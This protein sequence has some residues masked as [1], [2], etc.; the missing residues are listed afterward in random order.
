MKNR[1]FS[2]IAFIFVLSIFASCGDGNDYLSS[3]D[4]YEMDF[5]SIVNGEVMVRSA[6]AG[7]GTFCFFKIR[8]SENPNPDLTLTT[9]LYNSAG[10]LVARHKKIGPTVNA[11]SPIEL[12]SQLAQGQYEIS[13]NL[14]RGATLLASA[15]RSFF[16]VNQPLSIQGILSFPL[17]ISPSHTA[18]LIADIDAPAAGLDP[19]LKWT[20]GPKVLARGRLR[21]GYD[22]ILWESPDEDGVYSVE[23]EVYPFP[24][25]QRD[26]FAF[27]SPVK[28]AAE[29]YTSSKD[30]SKPALRST[31][32]KYNLFDVYISALRERERVRRGLT[33][34]ENASAA[35]QLRQPAP[36]ILG[37]AIGMKFDGQTG[38]AC[39]ELI[40]PI[41]A[42]TIDPFTLSL[43]ITVE[44]ETAG[45]R[46]FNLATQDGS[47]NLEYAFNENA[48]L[49]LRLKTKSSEYVFPSG[50]DKLQPSLRSLIEFSVAPVNG[51]TRITWKLNGAVISQS[52]KLITLDPG[53]RKGWTVIGG[54]NSLRCAIDTL[55]VTLQ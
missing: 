30:E 43:G 19:Y 23:V 52:E 4:R 49:I 39:P 46:I 24:P 15:R 35:P 2:I 37:E 18:L 40:V 7:A 34:V 36:V 54:E 31:T 12:S 44:G 13:L 51:R 6:Q 9:E 26:D 22:Q 50:I 10:D 14:T 11:D 27:V 55:D 5:N 17:V 33:A 42:K 38:F 48:E 32:L 3:A 53:D 29:L 47:L 25:S 1:F 28:A 8:G 21:D 45:R 16:L 41:R 20:Q